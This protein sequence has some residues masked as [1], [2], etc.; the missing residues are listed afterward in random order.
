MFEVP[1]PSPGIVEDQQPLLEQLVL[2]EKPFNQEIA[3]LFMKACANIIH[4]QNFMS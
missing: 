4:S 3:D 2:S 1:V